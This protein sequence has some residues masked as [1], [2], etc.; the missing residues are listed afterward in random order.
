MA[1]GSGASPMLTLLALLL[2][3]P[4]E[5]PGLL[6]RDLAGLS[7]AEARR[8][9]GRPLE[10]RLQ[11][12]GEGDPIGNGWWVWECD[13]PDDGVMRTVWAPR[14]WRPAGGTVQVVGH[15]EVVELPVEREFAG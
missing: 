9:D 3:A 1:P 4:P 13:G 8:F 5:P 2:I 15:V 12:A 14:G 11:P 7:L 10:V 6:V